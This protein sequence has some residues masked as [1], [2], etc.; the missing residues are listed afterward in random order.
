MKKGLVFICALFSASLALAQFSISGKVVSELS[1]E[2]L[3]AN[4]ILEGVASQATNENGLFA[5]DNV[6]MNSAACN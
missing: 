3:G 2:L 6:W 1:E 4:V 5:F